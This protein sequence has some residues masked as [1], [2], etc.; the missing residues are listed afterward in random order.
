VT[1][2][3][4]DVAIVGGGI[5]GLATAV[6]V[7][8]RFPRLRVA[9]L[10]KEPRVGLHQSG[11]NSGVVHSGVYYEPGS[12]KARLCVEGAVEM[13]LFCEENGVPL[14]PSTVT[15]SVTNTYCVASE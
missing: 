9:V 11:R 7:L 5:V 15:H 13:A 1:G 14:R 10:E 2:A 12:L 4:L 3:R 6:A 8:R